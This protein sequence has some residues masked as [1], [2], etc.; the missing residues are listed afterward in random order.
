M[1]DITEEDQRKRYSQ[2]LH[3]EVHADD[4][5]KVRMLLDERADV[6]AQVEN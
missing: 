4:I 1:G 3:D 2:A 6:H 5:E